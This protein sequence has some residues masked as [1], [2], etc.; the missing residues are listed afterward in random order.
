MQVISY[1]RGPLL[2]IFNFHPTNCYDSYTV[3]VEEAGEYEVSIS[4]VFFHSCIYYLS[5]HKY[6]AFFLVSLKGN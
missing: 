5:E 3:G 1:V 2:F 6:L 4:Y